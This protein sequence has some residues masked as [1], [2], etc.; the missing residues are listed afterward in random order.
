M[1]EDGNCFMRRIGQQF[2]SRLPFYVKAQYQ[3]GQPDSLG[4]IIIR[5][6]L[7]KYLSSL[8]L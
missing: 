7:L 1:W 4:I 5:S 3:D 6:F 2:V 8:L